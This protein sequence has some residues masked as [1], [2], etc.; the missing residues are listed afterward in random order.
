MPAE[1]ARIR[2]ELAPAAGMGF[3]VAD[4]FDG[5]RLLAFHALDL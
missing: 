5:D 2:Q 4:A 3:L 1:Q